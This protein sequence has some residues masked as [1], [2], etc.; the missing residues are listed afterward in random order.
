MDNVQK[1]NHC[2]H[3]NWKIISIND[4]SYI[5]WT[6]QSEYQRCTGWTA[7]VRFPAGARGFSLLDS[8][9]AD[10]ASYPMGMGGSTL[11][12][13]VAGS[14][15]WPP[16]FSAEVKNGRAILSLPRTPSWSGASLIRDRNNF[17]LTSLAVCGLTEWHR[18]LRTACEVE[19]WHFSLHFTE[20]EAPRRSRR[21]SC[22][23][24]AGWG[25]RPVHSCRVFN[26][27]HSDQCWTGSVFI[28]VC[29][30]IARKRASKH[31]PAEENA[32]N[33]RTSIARQRSCKQASLTI[34]DGVFRGV[35]TEELSWK[36]SAL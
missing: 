18:R 33:N 28:A 5:T 16:P 34:E 1:V 11:G 15:S 27:V 2:T 24:H 25:S 9:Q 10:S 3:T 21:T 23:G 29:T 20:R 26:T 12:N 7:G 32:R 6:A 17:I 13:K 31:I 4:I 30:P 22:C 14:W 19:C 35:R 36:Q 8:V